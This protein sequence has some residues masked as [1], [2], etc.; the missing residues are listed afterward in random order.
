MVYYIYIHC[1]QG[2]F[3]ASTAA[4]HIS[5]SELSLPLPESKKLWL[6][7]SATDWKEIYLWL[8]SE[9]LDRVP[10]SV[11]DCVVDPAKT[12]NLP[13]IYDYEFVHLVQVYSI[14]ALVREFKQSQSIFSL[15]EANLSR[16]TVIADEIQEKRLMHILDTVRIDHEKSESSQCGVWSMVRELASM[17]LHTF[18]DQIEVMAGR[19]GPGE[20][21][22]AYPIL[23]TWFHSQSS[24]QAV[25][26]AGQVLRNLRSVAPSN[27]H[28]FHAVACY[29]ASL[30]LW[31]YGIFSKLEIDDTHPPT[32]ASNARSGTILL[33]G[34]ETL[35]TQRWIV[36]KLGVP[37]I[38]KNPLSADKSHE[39]D[40]NRIP[41]DLT[42]E[43]MDILIEVIQ[44]KFHSN[45][46]LVPLLVQNIC[47]LMR[48][49]GEIQQPC[50]NFTSNR[51]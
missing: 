18:C 10:P 23:Y 28:V 46:R 15:R 9:Q 33:D 47:H 44:D 49:I 48:A 27:L 21:A 11:L 32:K 5:S 36:S 43:C 1:V 4:S 17:H 19:E 42:K 41:L 25:W 3:M 12:M 40:C 20:V 6:A 31:I 22:T 51:L 29:H 24:R 13:G 50:S 7:Q 30:C 35:G 2:E 8:H 38:S 45:S 39:T 37:V 16:E 34:E 14:S 26:H